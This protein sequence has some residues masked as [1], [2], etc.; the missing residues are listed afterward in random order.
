[1]DFLSSSFNPTFSFDLIVSMS[2]LEHFEHPEGPL[3]ELKRIAAPGGILIIGYPT[4]TPFFHFLHETASRLM[5]KRKKITRVFEEEDP[6][7]TFHAPHVAN[8]KMIQKAIENVGLKEDE[9][10]SIK[11]LPPF[12]E[13]YRINFLQAS[14]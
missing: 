6:D 9:R 2:V 11:L 1:M 5:P 14:H 12:F 10:K 3:K 7:E 8:A 4:E 13:L